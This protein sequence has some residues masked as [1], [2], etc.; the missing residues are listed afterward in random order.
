MENKNKNKE[1]ISYLR[2]LNLY[3]DIN[4]IYINIKLILNTILIHKYYK[5]LKYQIT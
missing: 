3:I 4:E 2:Y 5:I 1:K